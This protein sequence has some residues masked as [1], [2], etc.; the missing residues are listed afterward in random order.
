[1]FFQD[2]SIGF[3]DAALFRQLDG[4]LLKEDEDVREQTTFELRFLSRQI[5]K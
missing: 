5:R 1:M 3:L 2:V 4:N